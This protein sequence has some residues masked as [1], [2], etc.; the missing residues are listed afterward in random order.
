TSG[1]SFPGALES[2]PSNPA[3]S[4]HIR[5]WKG[6]MR[7]EAERSVTQWIESLKAGDAHAAQNLWQRYFEALVRQARVRLRPA[8]K[9]VADGEDAALSAF[10]SFGRG[11][12]R[13]RYPQLHDRDDLWRL[14]VVITERKAV[15][16]ARRQRRKKRGAGRVHGMPERADGDVEVGGARGL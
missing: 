8:P 2:P 11:G 7:D 10:D 15:D 12:A 9:A 5:A 6:T 3:T 14:L 4:A 16:Q 1:F 13:N